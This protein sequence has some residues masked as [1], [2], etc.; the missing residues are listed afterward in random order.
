MSLRVRK[1]TTR[2][3]RNA[4]GESSL[5]RNLIVWVIGLS[6]MF[7][8]GPGIVDGA[9]GA[10]RLGTQNGIPRAVEIARTT[11]IPSCT[12]FVDVAAAPGGNGSAGKPH[13]T[14]GAAIDA[15]ASGGVICVAEG[16]YAAELK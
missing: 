11:V 2:A 9:R 5:M 7:C 10:E 14:I 16:T 6:G 3:T 1:N 12:T 8:A 13:N 4:L 15:A